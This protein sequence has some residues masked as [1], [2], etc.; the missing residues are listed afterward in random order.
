[1]ANK[2]TT[3]NEQVEKLK[4]RGLIF[5]SG[6]EKVKEVLLDIGYYRLGFYWSPFEIDKD[7]NF[8]PGTKFS[9]VLALY[10][11]DVD[12]K[13]ILVR[14]LNRIEINFKTQLIYFASNQ[15][16]KDS[17][18]FTNNK[19]AEN[20]FVEGF[21][22]FYNKNIKTINNKPIQKH[23]LK[24]RNHKYAPAWKTIEF[25]SLGSTINLYDALLNESLK[26]TIAKQ[27]D[28]LSLQNFKNY[29]KTIRYIRN[30]CAHSDLLFDANTNFTILSSPQIPIENHKTH[31]LDTS[32]R[33]I[34]YFLS[35]ISKKRYMEYKDAINEL[36]KV[37]SNNQVLKTII[38]HKIGYNKSY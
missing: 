20:S 33:V 3:I 16:N 21:Y 19:I 35:Q 23:H 34:L 26:R 28:V 10:Y 29:L 22:N 15:Y 31:S 11:L 37:N 25:M 38:T 8:K 13:N 27:Y 36:F 9:D 5:D 6:I 1:M 2:A 4:S 14:I 7:H 30:I 24:Y 18:W 32:I 17:I 12:L